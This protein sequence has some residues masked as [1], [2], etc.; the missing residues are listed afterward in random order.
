MNTF[1]KNIKTLEKIQTCLNW[2]KT[3]LLRTPPPA[4]MLR[5]RPGAAAKKW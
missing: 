4:A 2:A 3:S 1:L 5:I